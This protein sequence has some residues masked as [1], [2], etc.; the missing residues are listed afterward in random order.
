VWRCAEIPSD[1][2][3]A[4][5]NTSGLCDDKLEALFKTQETQVDFAARQQTFYEITR[6]I[7]DQ[8]YWIGVWKDPDMF[9]FSDRMINVKMSGATAFY[10]VAEWDV[11]H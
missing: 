8:A 4:G 11:T 6:Y 10:N 7:F 2:N 9:G 5:V 3:P 1:E